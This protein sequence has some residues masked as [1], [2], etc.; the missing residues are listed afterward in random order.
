MIFLSVF[1]CNV[2]YT[3]SIKQKMLH[4]ALCR[5]GSKSS[6]RSN[7]LRETEEPDVVEFH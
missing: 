2:A 4:P 1:V 6:D 5:T 7:A 3:A